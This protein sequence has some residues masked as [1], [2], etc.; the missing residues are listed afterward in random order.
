MTAPRALRGIVFDS[1][2][3]L[4]RPVVASAAPSTEAWR[5]WFP[6][7]RIA[8]AAGSAGL[9]I[10]L[11]AVPHALEL[12]MEDLDE[13]H[14]GV[15]A[16]VDD[17]REAFR[18]FYR[19]VLEAAGAGRTDDAV[20]EALARAKVD[21]ERIE[22]FPEVVD[23]LRRLRARGLRLGVL[24]EG[25][26]SILPKYDELGLAGFFDAFV[27]SAQHGL[28]K[29]SP[30]LFEIVAEAMKLDPASMLYADDWPEHVATATRAGFDAVVVDRDGDAP[31]L[32]GV[33]YVRDLAELA[34]VVEERPRVSA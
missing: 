3:V 14:A 18:G 23:V 26:P 9:T 4:V 21:D 33:R 34:D 13:A 11:D 6:P 17:E 28:L 10:D 5:R 15:V 32:R 20:V 7:E 1:S 31:R 30:R 12:A 29:T 2:D 16:T 22:P 25:W 24:T 19:R 8:A 27:I